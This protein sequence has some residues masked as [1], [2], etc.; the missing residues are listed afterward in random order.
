MPSDRWGTDRLRRG[1]LRALRVRHPAQAVVVAFAVAV[2]VAAGLLALPVATESG[3]GAALLTALFTAVSAVCVTG[4]VVV[5]TPTYWSGF[6]EAVIIVGIQVGGFGIITLASLL[7]LAVS[8]RLGLRGRLA[9]QT[10]SSTVDLGDL[11]TVLRGVFAYTVAFE[12]AAAVVLTL[13]FLLA[14]DYTPVRAVYHGVFHS[15]SAFN[16]A[17]FALYSDNVVGFATDRLVT[18]VLALLTIAGGLGFPVL[19]DLARRDRSPGRWSLHT[20]LTLAVTLPLFALGS[21]A[22]LVFEWANPATLGPLAV[23][24]KLTPAAFH[25]V[26]PRTSGFNSLDVG[27]MSEPS[28]LV[29]DVLMFIG[30]G[31][32]GTAGGIK[33]TT[34][35][36]L[37]YVILAEVRG[38]HDVRLFDRRV[39]PGAQR[40]ALAVALLGLGA[41]VT[42]TLALLA[43][44]PLALSDALFEAVSAFGTVGM[45]TGI[46]AALPPAGQLVLIVLMFL[47]RVG[48]ITLGSALA[49]RQRELR[50]RLPEERPVIG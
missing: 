25:G 7:A 19:F 41:V 9:A 36:L 32:A 8:R 11:R 17:G 24:D 28:L 26:V 5:D 40:Q 18:G 31:S 6:G 33:V 16:N 47:G 14:Y 35:A 21:V 43:V 37:A 44:A 13:H 42:A 4:L 12:A 3:Q 23:V 46:T 45:S 39:A 29:T 2:L 50:Y 30:G 1:L 27:Q 10:E 15:V 49:L 20:K 34:F 38:E 48:P 22:I